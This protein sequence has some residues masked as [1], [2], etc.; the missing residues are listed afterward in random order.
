MVIFSF[1]GFRVP[2][3]PNNAQKGKTLQKKR[4]FT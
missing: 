3:H 1:A 2:F 4:K